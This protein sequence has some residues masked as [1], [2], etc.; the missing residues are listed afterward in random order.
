MHEQWEILEALEQGELSGK[1]CLNKA[2]SIFTQLVLDLW[3]Y[4]CSHISWIGVLIGF[5]YSSQHRGRIMNIALLLAT[6]SAYCVGVICGFRFSCPIAT[7]A[8]A[9]WNCYGVGCCCSPPG[10]APYSAVF[11]PPVALQP[12]LDGSRRR[13]GGVPPDGDSMTPLSGTTTRPQAGESI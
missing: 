9:A 11:S 3:C 2:V 10:P 12:Q 1:N 8:P 5:G 4:P 13:P 6:F 7:I